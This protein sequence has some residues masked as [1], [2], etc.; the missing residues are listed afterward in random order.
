MSNL[1]QLKGSESCGEKNA[2]YLHL[3]DYAFLQNEAYKEK[4]SKTSNFNFIKRFLV[5][6]IITDH[7]DLFPTNKTVLVKFSANKSDLLTVLIKNQCPPTNY[8]KSS[9]Q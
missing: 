7:Q 6:K 5:L 3:T 1:F 8:L 9:H 4:V 2:K